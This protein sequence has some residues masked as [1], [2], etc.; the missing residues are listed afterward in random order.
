[1]PNKPEQNLASVVGAETY[2]VWINMLNE[3][4]PQGRTHRLAPLVAGMLHY[5]LALAI[6]KKKHDEESSTASAVQSLLYAAEVSDPSEVE[7]YLREMVKQLF[8]DA[9]VNYNRTN[10][11]GKK[12]SILESTCEEFVNWYNMP[13]E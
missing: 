6:A 7:N 8:R 2:A 3:L 9:K 13:W 4:V 11:H 10:A 12:Y 1:M 5:A